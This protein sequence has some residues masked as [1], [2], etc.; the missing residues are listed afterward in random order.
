[1]PGDGSFQSPNNCS[2]VLADCHV[3]H[4]RASR[5]PL[6]AAYFLV[7]GKYCR[8]L[9]HSFRLRIRTQGRTRRLA[10]LSGRF[11]PL[12]HHTLSHNRTLQDATPQSRSYH[13][14]RRSWRGQ[15]HSVRA[16]APAIPSAGFDQLWRPVERQRSQT[17]SAW[18][19]PSQSLDIATADF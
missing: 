11:H 1:V 15:R 17:H 19:S 18:Y 16:Y 12:L 10:V 14:G 7:P 9:S 2:L 4:L 8:S 6:F 13:L 3:S 5:V